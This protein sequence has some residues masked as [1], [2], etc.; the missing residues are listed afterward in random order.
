MMASGWRT[1]S[2]LVACATLLI[3][4]GPDFGTVPVQG[5][6]T[7]QGADP[8]GLG[9][10]YFVPAADGPPRADG[11][12]QRSGSAMWLKDGN[13]RAGTFRADDGLRPGTY[14]V[15]I[16]CILSDTTS[17]ASPDRESAGVSAVPA[18]FRP[19]DLVVPADARGPVRYD[20]DVPR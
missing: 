15:R 20:L 1:V 3:G 7:F 14:T 16:E 4:C 12:G 11:S 5:R 18:G 8:P 13:F 6:V 2:P 9:Y 17:P 19:P 10:L